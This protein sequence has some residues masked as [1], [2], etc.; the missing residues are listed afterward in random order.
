MVNASPGTLRYD[1]S[2]APYA[3]KL[4][5]LREQLR[6]DP[7]PALTTNPNF[8]T[9]GLE[10]IACRG[11]FLQVSRARKDEAIK[12]GLLAL[13]CGQLLLRPADVPRPVPLSCWTSRLAVQRLQRPTRALT[14]W[15]AA[16]D[17]KFVALHARSTPEEWRAFQAAWR[18]SDEG[19]Q[20]VGG[21]A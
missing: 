9:Y 6:M 3:H 12:G 11:A 7:G 13:L 15:L 18:A 19:R 2:A 17:C 1:L 16:S 4:R 20:W 10:R 14:A 21:A 5:F 8:L